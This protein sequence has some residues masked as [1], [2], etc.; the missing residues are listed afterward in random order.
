MA[1]GV[2]GLEDSDRFKR[3]CT[4]LVKGF[5]LRDCEEAVRHVGTK[6][7]FYWDGRKGRIPG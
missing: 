4:C 5:V 6:A 3:G 2:S 1:R 7:C